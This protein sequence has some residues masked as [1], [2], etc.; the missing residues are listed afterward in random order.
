MKF[1][2]EIA[3]HKIF[4]HFLIILKLN[5]IAFNFDAHVLNIKND[6]RFSHFSSL[7]AWRQE[8]RND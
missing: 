3:E 1:L 7:E 2:L 8:S 6:Y 5:K 4:P